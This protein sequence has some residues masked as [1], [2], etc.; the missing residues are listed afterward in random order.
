MPAHS[1]IASP[2]PHLEW[3]SMIRYLLGGTLAFGA[4]NA[5]G[6]GLYGLAGAEGIPTAWLEGSPFTDYFVPS[7][8]LL[9]L[10]GGSLLFAAIAVYAR[11]RIARAA[12]LVAGVIVLGWIA[13]QVAIIGYVSWMQPATTLGALLILTLAWLH[14]PPGRVRSGARLSP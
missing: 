6:G 14:S 7:L 8:V 10:V 9:L 2:M 4:V 3:S 11:L 12:A 1:D 5:F 13:V